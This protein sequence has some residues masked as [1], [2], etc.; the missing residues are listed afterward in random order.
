VNVHQGGPRNIRQAA[1]KPV[2]EGCGGTSH[3][4]VRMLVLEETS[5]RETEA[6]A[7]KDSIPNNS[8]VD[9]G[10]VE[11]AMDADKEE[12]VSDISVLR[13]IKAYPSSTRG[14]RKWSLAPYPPDPTI[15]GVLSSPTL[16]HLSKRIMVVP[17]SRCLLDLFSNP[18]TNLRSSEITVLTRWIGLFWDLDG[19]RSTSRQ[20]PLLP[21]PE[22]S[23]FT[24]IL[25]YATIFGDFGIR[26]DDA[27]I[28]G[29][30]EGYMRKVAERP[31][32]RNWTR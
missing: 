31:R 16:T 9:N 8:Q 17:P 19:R 28:R 26:G 25:A 10:I 3:Q 6:E 22:P 11:G 12:G 13:R 27:R 23:T 4:K 2:R 1:E 20:R 5:R 29:Q 30:E 32:T 7:G 21:Q 15:H 18:P 24:H 14:Q